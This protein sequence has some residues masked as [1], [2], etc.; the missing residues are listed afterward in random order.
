MA[1]GELTGGFVHHVLK[2][3]G[4]RQFSFDA[5]PNLCAGLDRMGIRYRVNDYGHIRKHPEELACIIGRPFVLDW[6]AWKNPL[7]LGVVYPYARSEYLV[8]E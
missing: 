7:L 1:A 8:N 6:F 5:V 4:L 2:R 3:R